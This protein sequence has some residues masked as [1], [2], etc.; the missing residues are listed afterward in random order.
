MRAGF[1]RTLKTTAVFRHS[2]MTSMIRRLLASI[3][4]TLVGTGALAG[5]LP[6]DDV[7]D[8]LQ[9]WIPWVL[10]GQEARFCVPAHDNG[11]LR[12][13]HWPSQLALDLSAEGGRFELRATTLAPGWLALPGD[14]PRWP[15]DLRV[16]GRE[17]PV[18]DRQGVPALW[19]AAGQHRIE[20]RYSWG[21]LPESLRVPPD[22][23]LIELRLNGRVQSHPQRDEQHQ[24]WLGRRA[25]A[26]D[27]Q[28]ERLNLRVFRLID[29]D[30]PL[31]VTTQIEIDAGGEVRE[32]TIGPVLLEGL[33]PLS[34]AG[35]LP[36]R[37]ED[38]GR[39]RVQ[40]RPGLW[41]LTIVARS[42]APVARLAA[43]AAQEQ[44][45]AQEIWSLRAHHELRVIEPSGLPPTDPRQVG[46]P[47][48][49]QNLPAFVAEPGA[50]LEL[51]QTQR[52]SPDLTPDE[53]HLNRQLWLDFDGNGFTVQDQLGGRLARTWRLQVQDPITL[54][55]VQ[56]DNEPQLITRHGDGTGVEVR[57]G[58]LN[59]SA[60][61]R[62]EDGARRLPAG[63]W[64]TDLQGI[65]TTL[66]LPPAWR[67]LAAPGV[68]NVPD[69]WLSRWTLLDLFLVLIAS[70]AALR[71]FGAGTAALTLVT[72][73]LT[74]H[75]PGA[76]RW[77]W[78]NLIAAIAL[79]RAVPTSFDGSGRL[80]KLLF[81][82]QWLS[83][84]VLALIALPFA[85]QQARISLYP[86]LENEYGL[87]AYQGFD[88]YAGGFGVQPEY[89]EPF[90]PTRAAAPSM[91]ADMPA[92]APQ[93]ARRE[94]SVLQSKS[95]SVTQNVA[96]T[97]IR[98]L[99]PN[100]L[101]QTGPGLPA[102]NWRQ[103]S[104]N[105]S[106]PVT[107]GQDF[108]LWLMPPLVTRTL[109]WLSIALIAVLALRWLRIAPR[110]PQLP[111]RGGGAASLLA[112]LAVGG[113]LLAPTP[114]P[115]AQDNAAP[116]PILPPLPTQELLDELRE[117]LSAPPD[118]LPHCASWS[119]LHVEIG[120]AD[121][122]LLRLVAEAQIDTALPLPVPR[123]ATG[124]ARVW[125]PQT[126]LIDERNAELLRDKAGT[127]WLRVPA[128]RH[129][130]VV[131][132]DVAGFAQLQ[133]PA[134]PAPRHASVA[135]SGW[136]VSGIDAQ[137]RPGSVID[138]V[139]EQREEAGAT[140][141]EGNTQQLPPLLRLVRT[142]QLALVWSAEST[143]TRVGSAQGASIVTLPALPGEVVTGDSVRVVDGRIQASFAPGQQQVSWSSRIGTVDHLELV[144]SPKT[145]LIETWRFD[146]S[147]LWHVEFEGLP[148]VS[149]QEDDWRLVTFR[150]WPGEQVG[151]RI[152][153]PVAVQG[154]VMTL[155]SAELLTR[156]GKR[157]TD[158]T[159]SLLMRASQ[160]GQHAIQLPTGVSLQGLDIDGQ[161]QP[162][163]LEG[164][165][166][167]LPLR[168]GTQT[169]QL[170]LRADQ[171]LQLLTSTPSLAP[172]MPGVNAR[173]D[174][175]LPDRWVLLAGGPA[176]GPAVLFWGVL[177]VLLVVALALGRVG[178]TPL[179][180]M[181]WALLMIG[182]SQIPIAG[183]AIVAGWL[184]ALALRSR[185]PQG[186]S[187]RRFN[188]V[189]VVLA[190]W[191]V[192]AL[193]TLCGAVAQGLLGEPDMQI[194]GNGSSAHQLR[195]YQDRFETT[196]PQAWVLSV[197]IWFYRGLMLLWSLW[198][199]NSLLNW[200]R[201]GWSQY[202]LGG[203]WRRK[204]LVTA[205][206]APETDPGV[207]S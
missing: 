195:W 115:A 148:A 174:V 202:S 104:L 162:A 21:T 123:V 92:P 129:S 72:L 35:D 81:G 122:L 56:V 112:A 48:T 54:G 136:R 161:A 142:L 39:L 163:R 89:E 193:A 10:H 45:A 33:V 95:A 131:S 172:G 158:Y 29:D 82:Y 8:P 74:W 41:R 66:H 96:Q 149:S 139:R 157:A 111:V 5:P 78:L 36:A 188:L 67:L 68:D 167:I 85:V 77:A 171:G 182:L 20:G 175:Q 16:N 52:G 98:K 186:W 34:I 156:P 42:T 199:A 3:A 7:P 9:S 57:H 206:A 11:G 151:A 153:R 128:G 46:V 146:V 197:S 138:L 102:W 173:L 159:L 47:A 44:W 18:L 40:L 133:L 107:A 152:T 118:C 121:R 32:Q 31:T 25:M 69:T 75:E 70:I 125:Q 84:G 65:Q 119:R 185:I 100:V 160:G 61:S 205:P 207:A 127:L 198:L 168:P 62:I 24:L 181:Q 180:G 116:A 80:R 106:G 108:R 169:L 15:Q 38:D 150:P 51:V 203:L 141:S 134:S 91:E 58:V 117:R 189:Q 170:R 83:A 137:G 19:L 97:S 194:A 12:L 191:T 23:G 1:A 94:M 176:L 99:D 196:L 101:T 28:A 132:G 103:A 60:D 177:V 110:L 55:R 184:F 93:D 53:L 86:Q 200:L 143:L 178:M 90:A 30:I 165:R 179:K 2:G 50:A 166:V 154:Q 17:A 79:L 190:L 124:Q 192:I 201:W 109:G 204:P 113:A 59:L 155:D 120:D 76:P 27:A 164:E 87:V 147:P 135:A 88:Q 145:D 14:G 43:P 22:S 13:C 4:L 71:L 183:A 105:W 73:A 144:A 114:A 64:N 140:A 126:V 6:A 37:L 26:G 63:G 130:V 49:W 187:V